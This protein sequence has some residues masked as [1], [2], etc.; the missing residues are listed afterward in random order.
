MFSIVN[1]K[2]IFVH[3]QWFFY[4]NSYWDRCNILHLFN[5]D[6]YFTY[7]IEYSRYLEYSNIEQGN[8]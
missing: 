4:G 2:Y 8:I 5:Y 6:K 7:L 1:V 3:T